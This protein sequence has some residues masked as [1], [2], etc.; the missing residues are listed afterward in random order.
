MALTAWEGLKVAGNAM[1]KVGENGEKFEAEN[2]GQNYKPSK[3][4]IID[5]VL[6]VLSEI[7]VEVSD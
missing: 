5:M 6:E 7:G 4:E 1:A 2:P 3:A